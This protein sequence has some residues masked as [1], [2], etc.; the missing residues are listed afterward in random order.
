MIELY[1][2]EIGKE[3]QTLLVQMIAAYPYLLRDHI[4]PGCLCE[5]PEGISQK[6]RLLIFGTPAATVDTRYEG[7]KACRKMN[8]KR[9]CWV[10]RTRLPW[11]LFRNA[12]LEKMARAKNR[13]LWVC[14]RLGKSIMGIQYGPNYTSRE[15]LTMLSMV[16]KLTDAL[17]QCERIHQTAVPL[18]YARHSLRSLT[19]WLFT[20]PFA[21][22]KDMGML[23][24]PVVGSIAWLLYGIYQIGYSIE[25]PFQGSLRLSTLCDAIRHDVLGSVSGESEEDSRH[26]A[27]A[28]QDNWEDGCDGRDFSSHHWNHENLIPPVSDEAVSAFLR[29]TRPRNGHKIVELAKGGVRKDLDELLMR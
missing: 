26:T 6:N 27:Y 2:N 11:S 15:R 19:L 12:P 16:G 10:D 18:N 8:F 4:R 1:S 5:S 14:D 29:D 28:E 17:G 25:D 24:A 23:T 3:R 21:L 7:D 22:V 9:N 13:P 20:L